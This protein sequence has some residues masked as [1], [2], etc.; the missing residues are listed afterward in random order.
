MLDTR[1]EEYLAAKMKFDSANAAL[2]NLQN[3]LRRIDNA[4][5]S[6]RCSNRIPV[7][8]RKRRYF[9]YDKLNPAVMEIA[10]RLGCLQA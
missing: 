4:L 3:D 9:S 8:L 1:Q 5:A 10:E 2:E 6:L 7:S